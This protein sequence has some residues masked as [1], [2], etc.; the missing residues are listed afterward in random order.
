MASR[1]HSIM[2]NR[3][4]SRHK[5]RAAAVTHF[6]CAVHICDRSDPH[7]PIRSLFLSKAAA[8]FKLQMCYSRTPSCFLSL[9]PHTVKVPPKP[10]GWRQ[11]FMP[12]NQRPRENWSKEPTDKNIS[13]EIRRHRGPPLVALTP[14]EWKLCSQSRIALTHSYQVALFSGNLTPKL[15]P[16]K[17]LGPRANVCSHMMSSFLVQ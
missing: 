10:F 5:W 1:S 9:C 4:A 14:G 11:S 13:P 17:M 7:V 3:M 15:S 8:L 2:L 16:W 12:K 6:A